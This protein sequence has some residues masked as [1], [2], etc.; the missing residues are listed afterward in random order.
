LAWIGVLIT[1]GVALIGLQAYEAFVGRTPVTAIART[2][3]ALL[4]IAFGLG[5]VI[6]ATRDARR[7]GASQ[8]A[9]EE[10]FRFFI[11]AV[12]DYAIYTLDPQGRVTSWNA[13]AARIKGYAAEEVVGEDSS[14]FYTEEDRQAGVPEKTLERAAREGRYEA[15]VVRVR[16]DG[17]R[18]LANVV[19]DP[20]RDESGHIHHNRLDP[21]VE[22]IVKPFTQ[23]DLAARVRRLLTSERSDLR[24]KSR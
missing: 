5:L 23:S 15:E 21:G 13:G 8:R 17:S 11:Q 2:A 14:R 10:R 18:F 16:K 7:A 1:S 20:V 22:L 6:Y 4:L 24:L 12:T 3:F 9:T 19:I